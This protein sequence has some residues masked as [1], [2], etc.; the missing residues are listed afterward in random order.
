MVTFSSKCSSKRLI[1]SLAICSLAAPR[2]LA[3]SI[4]LISAVTETTN[5]PQLTIT[6]SNFGTAQP[7]VT[8]NNS[9]VSVMS[10]T[11]TLV[12]VSVPP[13]IES[14]PGTYALTLTN[15]SDSSYDPLRTTV[16]VV[17]IGTVGP[18]GSAGPIGPQ[19][20]AGPAGSIGPAGAMGPAGPLGP[21]GATGAAGPA[22]PS[23]VFI[24]SSQTNVAALNLTGMEVASLNNLPAGNYI[25]SAKVTIGPGS[26]Q[27]YC[28]LSVSGQVAPIDTSYT[29]L[30][31][32]VL[33]ETAKLLGT[34]SFANPSNSV[35][36]S[37]FGIGSAQNPVLTAT[38]V[39]SINT[40]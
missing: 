29:A 23:A 4:P 21:P 32:A 39:G 30:G 35:L 19:G 31:G 5:P 33:F 15:N 6:G 7:A 22:G 11:N 17:A 3:E 18:A 24:N 38:Q 12:V 37:C 34:V 25:L 36:V 2:L 20:N 40:M 16:F 1:W 26:G 14:T 10:Y 28:T 9:S 8:L 13:S 27:D